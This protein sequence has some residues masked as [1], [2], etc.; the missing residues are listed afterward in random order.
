MAEIKI[1]VRLDSLGNVNPSAASLRRVLSWV[2]AS[3]ATSVEL[4]GRRVLNV[5]ELSDTAV[6][7]LRK[8]LDDLN[9]RIAS[10]RFPTRHGFDHLENLDRRIEAT[11]A[12]MRAAYRLGAPLVVNQIGPV[13]RPPSSASNDSSRSGSGSSASGLAIGGLPPEGLSLS[14]ALA[15]ATG[16]P[17]DASSEPETV[18]PRW[19]TLREVLDDLGRFGAR[20]GAFFAAETGTEPGEH[21]AR[22]IDMSSEAYIAVALNP[23][24]LIINRHSVPDAVAALKDRI[25]IVNAVD[26]VLDLSAGR[27]IAVPVGQGTADFPSLL[28]Q[29]EDIPYRGPF[30]VGR[31]GMAPETAPHEIM[32]SIEYLRNL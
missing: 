3:G 17:P 15:W 2:A 19:N 4:C 23:G 7:T 11:K 28:G 14:E 26:G 10:I 6:R 12:A 1:A 22:L 20:T 5:S 24:Q 25:R 21:L 18:D 9:L 27:G 13:P 30:V 8:I 32:Q 29:L 31:S 16:T